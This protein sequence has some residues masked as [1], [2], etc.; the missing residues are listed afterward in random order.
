ME[1]VGFERAIAGY[2]MGLEPRTR[3]RYRSDV[4]Q[5][6]T[7]CRDNLVDPPAAELAHLE[8]YMRWLREVRGLSKASVRTRVS[9]VHGLYR[10]AMATGAISSDPFEHVRLPRVYGHSAGTSLDRD[11]AACFLA[12]ARRRGGDERALCSVL[13]LCGLRVSEAVSLDVEDYAP[14]ARPTATISSRK[15]DWCQVAALAPAVADAFDELVARRSG[16]PLLRCHGRR[17]KVREARVAVVS[18]AEAVGLDGITPHSLRR[19]FAT[20]SRDAGITDR[21]IRKR[22]FRLPSPDRSLRYLEGV[23]EVSLGE[24]FF[25]P[26]P[27]DIVSEG[28]HGFLREWFDCPV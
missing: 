1:A 22:V 26:E 15:G 12:E 19:T 17:M 20:L 9:S 16:G 10:Y 23:R 21:D 28:A 11:E 5:W 6:L 4:K 7:W 24:S 8:G 14:G 25:C 2:L 3:K 13:L 18:V 27:C